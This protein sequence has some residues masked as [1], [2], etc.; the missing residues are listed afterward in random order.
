MDYTSQNVYR[1]LVGTYL[2]F[3]HYDTAT[4]KT[5]SKA[6]RL[7]SGEF[8][9]PLMFENKVYRQNGVA[10]STCST[11][12]ASSATSFWSTA[13]SSRIS[14]STAALPLPLLNTGPSRFY[15]SSSATT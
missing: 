12:T 11:W 1:G 15:S 13:T 14:K 8:D 4:R 2:L 5:N 7:P 6:I 9:V 3:D 10:I